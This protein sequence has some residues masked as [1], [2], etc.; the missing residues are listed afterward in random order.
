MGAG[1]AL[2][3]CGLGSGV[4]LGLGLGGGKGGIGSGFGGDDRNTGPRGKLKEVK[5]V[6]KAPS[7]VGASGMVFSVGET[8]GAPDVTTPAS[9]P[10]TDVLSDYS[11]AAE[12]ALA[13]EKVP[14]AYR[15]RVKDYF[16]S[17]AK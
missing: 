6:V 16:S 3:Q 1:L 14:P 12:T 8:K 17:L 13:K 9:V 7:Q 11:K 10:Y 2:G 15:V 5:D 4:G